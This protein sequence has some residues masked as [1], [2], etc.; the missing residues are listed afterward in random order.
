MVRGWGVSKASV[1]VTSKL[2]S[3]SAQMKERTPYTWLIRIM[4]SG[5]IG[6]GL[7]C[8]RGTGHPAL[9]CGSQPISRACC[10][11]IFRFRD[12]LPLLWQAPKEPSAFSDRL[13]KPRRRTPLTPPCTFTFGWSPIPQA[14]AGSYALGSSRYPASPL[15]P[16]PTSPAQSCSTPAG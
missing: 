15:N 10:Q 2:R 14:V 12:R 3:S 9:R 8:L 16:S 11:P 7:P 5:L 1:R 4:G 6:I 13:R